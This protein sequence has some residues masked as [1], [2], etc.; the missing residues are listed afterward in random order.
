MGPFPRCPGSR[1]HVNPRLLRL[2]TQG[3]QAKPSPLRKP[4]GRARVQGIFPTS[5]GQVTHGSPPVPHSMPT[6]FPMP[7]GCCMASMPSVLPCSARIF[8]QPPF[9]V[10]PILSLALPPRPVSHRL[11]FPTLI[12]CLYPTGLPATPRRRPT[13]SS[14][15]R[16][17][18]CDPDTSHSHLFAVLPWHCC[19]GF[20]PT[21][22]SRPLAPVLS[23]APSLIPFFY[24]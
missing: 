20:W 7:R 4:H 12:P 10:H 22:A 11:F 17:P 21:C 19:L 16:G 1:S 18:F 14:S 9:P 5:L 8:L 2:L 13:G 6:T 3:P 23:C 24:P 15:I